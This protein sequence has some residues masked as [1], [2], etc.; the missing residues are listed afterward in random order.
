V[1]VASA[2]KPGQVSDLVQLGNAYTIIRLISHDAPGKVKF[3]DVRK[4]LTEHLQK[5]KYE[6]L[7]VA[8][9]KRLR[10]KAKIEKL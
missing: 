6:K 9:G 8:L 5:E 10:Q 2:L 4:G 1:K 7:R 3:E